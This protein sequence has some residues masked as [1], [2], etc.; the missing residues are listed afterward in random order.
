VAKDCLLKEVVGP[1][2]LLKSIEELGVKKVQS[3]VLSDQ[4]LRQSFKVKC[5][6]S[7]G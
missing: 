7:G 4:D 3:V 1:A 2:F 6:A 5:L